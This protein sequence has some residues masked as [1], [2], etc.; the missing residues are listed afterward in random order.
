MP[1][2][3]RQELF[4]I[5]WENKEMELRYT[6]LESQKAKVRKL[7]FSIQSQYSVSEVSNHFKIVLKD[8][9]GWIRKCFFNEYPLFYQ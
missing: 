3:K 1:I 6:K 5:S 2:W 9:L 7:K 8:T 4:W